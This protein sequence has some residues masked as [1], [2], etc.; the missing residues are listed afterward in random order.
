LAALHNKEAA[1]GYRHFIL[2]RGDETLGYPSA[3]EGIQGLDEC[4]GGQDTDIDLR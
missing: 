3:W 2:F 4:A 1:S